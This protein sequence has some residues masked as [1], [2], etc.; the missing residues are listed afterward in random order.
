MAQ[1]GSLVVSLAMDTAKFAGDVGKAARDMQKLTVAAGK[2]GAA[3]GA[4]LATAGGVFAAMSKS[5]IDAADTTSKLAQ[6][7]GI[8]TEELSALGYAAEMAG[9]SQQELGANLG[10]LAKRASEAAF[11]G[12]EAQSVFAAMGV[13]VR[14]AEGGLKTTSQLLE[15]IADKFA[16]YKDGAEKTALAQE[17]FGKSG[18]ALIPLLNGG[19]AG[20]AEM[21][22][23]AQKMGIVLTTKTGKAAEQFNDN[24]SRLTKVKNGLV[25]Q[26]TQ[27]LLP[28]LVS[29]SN[30]FV[31]SAKNSTKFRE[32]IVEVAK[33]GSIAL[34][35]FVEQAVL[36]ARTIRAIGGLGQSIVADLDLLR[37]VLFA[38]PQEL[39]Q[40]ITQG[41]GVVA[42]ALANRN[43]VVN[44]AN[45]RYIELWNTD[46]TALSRAVRNAFSEEARILFNIQN[47]PRELA[48]RSRPRANPTNEAPII[49][50]AKLLGAGNR[51]KEVKRSVAALSEFDIAARQIQERLARLQFDVDT[52]GA[53]DRIRGLLEL[54]QQG[55][56]PEQLS[57][58]LQLTDSIERY[59][60]AKR[61]EAEAAQEA[62]ARMMDGIGLT[63][64]LRT[65]LEV[66]L[67]EYERYNVLL[68]EN[69]I[70]QQTY[71]RAVAKAQEDFARATEQT[72][73]VNDKFAERAAENIQSFLGSSLQQ[74]MEGNFKNIGSAFTAMINRMVAEALAAN[75]MRALMGQAASFGGSGFIGTLL[76]FGVSL[77]GG[78]AI[79]GPVSPGRSYLVGERGPEVFTPGTPG[80]V[81][82]ND[83]MRQGRSII[84]NV[85]ATPGMSRETALQ[86]GQQIGA[87]IQRF[88]ARGA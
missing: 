13:D 59:N 74:A 68:R 85:K 22:A 41:T 18:A 70:S 84:V 43:R 38:S 61:R 60:E 66:L 76:N 11:G 53:S 45:Q 47:D 73:E 30:Q 12:R 20:I 56:T 63:Q 87:G 1:L 17:I 83:E 50:W 21:T 39:R 82:S 48:R 16:G 3:I 79:G 49:D 31:G 58:Y 42:E 46:R 71:A 77:F 8:A 37:T 54:R 4:A 57:R 27:A 52:Q 40:A 2:I 34:A 35:L 26:I 64:S 72:A 86:Q 51:E 33:S 25:L 5:A 55:A 6:S 24:L 62:N 36:L 81:T 14:N 32:A 88:M 29:I 44:E 23:E 75:L 65:P 67:D 7:V 28:S 10:R 80:A 9:V 19:R 15:E 78:K 69:A